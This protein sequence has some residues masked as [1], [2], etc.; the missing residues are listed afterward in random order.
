MELV[1]PGQLVLVKFPQT[2]LNEGKLRPVLILC[3]LPGNFDDWLVCMVSTKFR[4]FIDD[5]D[6]E[7]NENDADFHLSGLK[8]SCVFRVLRIA[9]VNRKIMIGKTGEISGTRLQRI[10]TK[11]SEWIVKK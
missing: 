10:K 8:T 9:I 11:I 6:D 7:I 3:K 5:I 2:D 4:Q 1:K